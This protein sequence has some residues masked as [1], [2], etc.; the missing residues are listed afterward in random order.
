MCSSDLLGGGSGVFRQG[1]YDARHKEQNEL[2]CNFKNNTLEYLMKYKF[3]DRF[4][5][6]HVEV[7]HNNG[8]PQ[9]PGLNEDGCITQQEREVYKEYILVFPLNETTI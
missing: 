2:K 6:S 4:G 3:E 9:S 7:V 5:S 1:S 8:A